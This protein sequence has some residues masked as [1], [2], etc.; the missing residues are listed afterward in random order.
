MCN[1][2]RQICFCLIVLAAIP[3]QAQRRLSETELVKLVLA[4]SRAVRAD[5]LNIVQ[6]RH[7][8]SSSLNIPNPEFFWESPTGKFY[9]GSITQSIEFPA[10]YRDQL[11]LQRQRVMLARSE[12]KVTE[13]E[14]RLRARQLYLQLQVAAE[15]KRQLAA[16]D[17]L[18]ETVRDASRRQF[19]AGQI[20]YLQQLFAE[21]QYG[22]VHNQLLQAEAEL[23]GLQETIKLLTG[24]SDT[25]E[26]DP[27]VKADAPE[28]VLYQ[29]G[30]D[31]L[32]GHPVLDQLRQ[33]E[34]I[35]ELNISLQRAKALP[36]LAFGYF[37][38]GERETP[39]RNR[40][41][42][43]LTIPL[44]FWQYTGNINAARAEAE[45]NRA[46][47]EAYLQQTGSE[48]QQLLARSQGYSRAV[49]YFEQNGLDRATEMITTARRFF[50]AGQ[51]DYIS[52]LRN[53]T[54]AYNIRQRYLEALSNYNDSI[55]QLQFLTG[56]L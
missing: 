53:T 9:T 8:I 32:K 22:E 19:E 38:Q 6:Q 33:T 1:I 36:G 34:K 41:R 2:G 52:L 56:Q 24:V 48:Y 15:R 35:G 3:L 46:R 44:W 39:L 54:E 28:P 20:D 42:F 40:F 11:R 37:N 47:T 50:A 43:G 7:L 31:L 17:S 16:Q 12:K 51:I 13:A 4:N 26:P 14:Q 27:P 55:L 49:G 29:S 45:Q 30:D 18:Y 10:V 25:F 21:T 23:T 5:S